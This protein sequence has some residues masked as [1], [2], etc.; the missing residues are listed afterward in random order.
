MIKGMNVGNKVT[1][2]LAGTVL[3]AGNEVLDGV[4]GTGVELTCEAILLDIFGKVLVIP[5]A[6]EE[7][8]TSWVAVPA[9]VSITIKINR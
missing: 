3:C 6:G 5:A 2:G 7:V 4:S 1:T 9:I 8:R